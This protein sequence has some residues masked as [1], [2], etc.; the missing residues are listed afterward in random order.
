MTMKTDKLLEMFHLDNE[1]HSNAISHALD[2]GYSIEETNLF[3]Q[4]EFWDVMTN[5]IEEGRYHTSPTE[6]HYID[7]LT[8]NP[9]TYTEATKRDFIDVRKIY[10]M[11]KSDR[12]VWNAIYQVLYKTYSN[13]IHD[14][15]C[16]YKKGESTRKVI[17][18]V[19]SQLKDFDKYS[20][21]KHDL[22]KYFDSVPIEQIDKLFDE[23]E[24]KEPS[25][26]WSVI[27]EFY[28]DNR[29][30]VNGDQ[31]EKYCS[32]KQGCA[33]SAFL[34]N[35]I[36]K[37]VDEFMS[38]QPVIYY[39]YSDDCIIIGKGM[40]AA[41]A[42]YRMQQK[43]VEKGLSFNDKKTE[44]INERRWVTFLG[45]KMKK[46]QVTVSKKSLENMT[47]KIKEETIF[48]CKQK[49]RALTENELKKA[50][51]N[52]QYYFFVGCEKFKAG[53]APY[54]FGACNDIEDIRT[55]DNFIKDCLRA[56]YTNKCD[57][58]GLSASFGEHGIVKGG[59][60]KT[61][62]YHPG[63]NVGMNLVKTEGLLE[64]LGYYSLVHMYNKF[65]QGTDVFNAEINKMRTGEC[66]DKKINLC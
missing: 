9:L 36:L 50:I 60:D 41:K 42:A 59:F 16:S 62:K 23:L 3:F 6:E 30:I 25:K 55:I 31:I 12:V 46:G 53:M 29:I 21:T 11:T 65:H 22:T 51:D 10:V 18:R 5:L 57:I 13:M 63:R 52:I 54:L 17:K 4:P 1:I 43:L 56:A 24:N 33:V 45:F 40:N 8:G 26:L 34:S 14:R 44:F 49:H 39:R 58:Y 20:G 66:Y 61:G 28:H 48:K 32:L 19:S 15:C 37:D 47:H 38:K 64:R 35:L 7:K 27:R 2:K